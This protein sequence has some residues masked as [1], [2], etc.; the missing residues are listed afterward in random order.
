GSDV[1]QAMGGLHAF[2]A[3]GG[4][5]LTDSGGFQVFSLADR[6]QITDAGGTFRS[7]LDGSLLELTPERATSIQQE[8]GGDGAMCLD[9][10]PALPATKDLIAEA[11][12]RTIRWA[13]RCRDEHNR[14]DQALF[15][16]VQGGSHA[17][18]RAECAERLVAMGFDGYAV[19]GVSVGEARDEVRK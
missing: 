15:G 13:Q 17:D 3:W 4:P 8:L 10:F 5:I 7:H 12:G 1:V 9:Q 2:M 14:S 11:V 6:T 19:G 16:I 18:L